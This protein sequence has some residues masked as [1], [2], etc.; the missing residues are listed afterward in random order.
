[1]DY[2]IHEYSTRCK[3]AALGLGRFPADGISLLSYAEHDSCKYSSLQCVTEILAYLGDLVANFSPPL[4]WTTVSMN[5]QLA[6]NPP[7]LDLGVG[8][9]VESVS[10]LMPNT[11][12]ASIVHCNEKQR[13]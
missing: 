6:V 5:I 10:Y 13:F 3:Q 9:W 12:H 8:T 1:M 11:I 2:G 4:P 7:A